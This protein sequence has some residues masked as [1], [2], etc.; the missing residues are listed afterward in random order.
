MRQINEAVI[1]CT[2]TRPDFMQG[3]ST[4]AKVSEVRRW[5]MQDRGWSDIGYHFLIDRSGQVAPGRPVARAGA[6]VKGHNKDTIGIALFGG[7]GSSKTDKFE[8]HFTA[9]QD[10]ALRKLLSDLKQQYGFDRVTGHNQWAA[11]ACPGFLVK[12]WLAQ[13]STETP[14][15]KPE[16]QKSWW[17]WLFGSRGT[18]GS[19]NRR[20]GK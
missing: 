19:I 4:A 8:Q 16:P 2:A 20:Q 13:G 1:H 18:T 17:S 15:P 12:E 5:H 6:H 11:K 3:F 9:A 10:A 7:H 14:E